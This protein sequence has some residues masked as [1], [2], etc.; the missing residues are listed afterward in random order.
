M[1]DWTPIPTIVS[2]GQT[3]VDRG[4]LSAAL[5]RGV[6]CGG[7]CPE[8]RVAED[9]VIPA[10]FP[11]KELQGGTYSER[12]LKN[13]VDSDGTLVI[14]NGELGGG[15]G[16]TVDFC[17]REKK[18]YCLIHASE[19]SLDQSVEQLVHFIREHKISTLNVAGPRA[20]SWANAEKHVYD[21]VTVFLK[22]F[23]GKL[24]ARF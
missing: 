10:C 19:L 17:V 12:T 5:D 9:G 23:E 4:A 2:G 22:Y 16:L 7:W 24:G 11:L 1:T 21:F 13:V 6:P 18:P 3:G 20:S 14:S 15:S 8:G